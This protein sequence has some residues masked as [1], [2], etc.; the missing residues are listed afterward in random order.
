MQL[1]KLKKIDPNKPK[2]KKILLLADDFRLPSGIGTISREIIFNTVRHYDW[3][4]LGGALKHPE[5]GQAFD[6]S[7]QIAQETGIEDA[8]VKIIPWNGYGDRN[9]L[10]A[11][12][13]NERPD[14]IFHFTDPRYWTWLYAIEHEIKTTFNI[15]II[16]YSIWDDLPYPMW[17]APFYASCDLIMGI[18]KQSDNIHREVLTQNGF[19]VVNYDSTQ[20][21]PLD[22]KWNQ[23]V[24]G[25]VPHGLNHNTFKP[26]PAD[27]ETRKRV[28]EN[29][30]TKHG[31]DFVVFW[32]NRNIRRKQPGDVIL[33]FKT[34]VDS[35][36]KDQ[37]QR[38]ALLM[39]TQIVDE[40][41][42]DLRAIFKTLAP[43]CKILF[44]EQKLSHAELNAMY[45]VADVVVNIGSNEGWGLSSTEAMLS[46]TPIINNVTGGLQDQ[47][48]FVDE[49]GEWIRFDGEFATNHTGKYK[50]HGI[51]AKPVFPSNRSL[52]GSPQT[53]Y[54]FDDRCK[55]EDVADAIRYWY[56]T[57][58]TLR[59][60]MGQSG[61]EWALQNGLTAEQMGNKMIEM[62]D[63]LFASKLAPRARYSLTKVTPKKYEK[64]GIVCDQL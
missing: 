51:W 13:N 44:S 47:C 39:H 31:V 58:E 27:D 61:R 60:Q 12:I 32:N 59:E 23:I 4:Q 8:S 11:I 3:V 5:A 21:V 46:G 22:V 24:T 36:P 16:Y 2:K 28:Y 56:D 19:D 48:G 64:T 52:Q 29:I 53:P 49:N 20:S 35:L 7:A 17:N 45:N 50:L 6:L 10:M 38:V 63:Y 41:G 18:S 43:D 25:Y 15:P 57:P 26:L 9:I 34:F 37:K 42:T 54:I 33:A 14:A 62:I 30:K 40:N 55:Y 1:P